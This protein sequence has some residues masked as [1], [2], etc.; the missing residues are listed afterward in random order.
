MVIFPIIVTVLCAS[1][2]LIQFSDYWRDGLLGYNG[3]EL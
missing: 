1:I 2:F 3:H